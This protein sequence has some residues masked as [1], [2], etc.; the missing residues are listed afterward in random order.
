MLTN[1]VKP[2]EINLE[3]SPSNSDNENNGDSLKIKKK[4]SKLN[5]PKIDIN[6]ISGIFDNYATKKTITTGFFNIALVCIT[7]YTFFISIYY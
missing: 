2:V 7:H 6:G 3:T 1:Q 5:I 4:H